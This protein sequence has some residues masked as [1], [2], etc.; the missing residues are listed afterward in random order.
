MK[1]FK[2]ICYTTDTTFYSSIEA[3]NVQR[4]SDLIL[5]ETFCKSLIKNNI[6]AVINIFDNDIGIM[7][8]MSLY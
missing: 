3:K 4:A 6:G 8:E 2:Y 1:N 7:I 5:K